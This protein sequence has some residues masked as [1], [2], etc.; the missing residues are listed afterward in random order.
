MKKALILLIIFVSTL[1]SCSSPEEKKKENIRKQ[2]AEKE[3]ALSESQTP[4]R[5]SAAAIVKL[6]ADYAKQYP[7][8]KDSPDYLF[9]AG[10]ISSSMI[11]SK[12]AIS[13]LKELCDKYP[14]DS[15]AKHALFLQAFIYETQLQDQVNAKAIYEQVIAKYP[16]DKL[17]EDSKAM[18]ANLGKTD[19]QLIREFEE[20][21]K[22]K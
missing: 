17:A 7:A 4:D 10:E 15:K 1:V 12:Q 5:A 3:K 13:Y 20:K 14:D 16:G 2:I 8:D 21:N 9:K 11:D 18:I 19:E 6:Y 22:G